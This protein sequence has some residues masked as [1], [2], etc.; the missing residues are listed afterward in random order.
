MSSATLNV[1]FQG[2]ALT[3]SLLGLL[4]MLMDK[5]KAKRGKRRIPETSFLLISIVGGGLGVCLGGV[6]FSHKTSKPSFMFKIMLGVLIN[7]GLFYI[8][9][10]V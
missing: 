2:L 9:T 3:A 10:R 8:A 1:I 5:S 4:L 7:I 6:L